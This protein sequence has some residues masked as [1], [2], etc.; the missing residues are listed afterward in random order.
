MGKKVASAS[1]DY[2]IRIMEFFMILVI[3]IDCNSIYRH[4]VDVT[5]DL[6]K[7]CMVAS[8]V[9]AF[10]LILL[11]I[12]KDKSNFQCILEYRAMFFLSA[13]FC[14]E[15]NAMNSLE[16]IR[17]DMNNLI[18]N[19]GEYF[20]GYFLFFM[21][22]MVILFRIYRK[23]QE[24]FRLLWLLE[25]VI[26]FLAI[27]SLILWVGTC[28]LELWGKGSDVY[29]FWGGN[30][31]YSNHLNLFVRRWWYEG[32]LKKNLGIFVEPPMYGLFLGFGLYTELFMK[33]KS[34]L[35]IVAIFVITLISCR[36]ILAL[37]ISL[38]GILFLFT[39]LFRKKKGA[40]VL[41]P[42]FWICA[43]LGAVALIIYKSKVGWGSFSVHVDDFVAC[44]KC[45]KEYPIFGCGYDYSYPIYNYVSSF[46]LDNLG[47][48][49]SAG[50]VLAEGGILLFLYYVIP[51]ALMMAAFFKGNRKLAYWAVGMFLFW[52][53]VIFHARA[54]VFF[55]MALGYSMIDVETHLFNKKDDQKRIKASLWIFKENQGDE[56][57][58]FQKKILNVPDGFLVMMGTILCL[59]VVYG[60][61]CGT[62]FAL[63]N[64]I[65]A[66]FVLI[67]EAVILF[68]NLKGKKFTKR[69]NTLF[70]MEF[71]MIYV[72]FGQAYQVL[73]DFLTRARLRTQD[74]WWSF[75]LLVLV[76]YG[77]G[78]IV[79]DVMKKRNKF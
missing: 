75:P 7:W 33:K 65:A 4:A 20:I 72:L 47:M 56:E 61:T 35:G 53:V 26:L 2:L 58:W 54:F 1:L 60:L 52:V 63:R 79:N 42:T 57:G 25:N 5:A 17:A 74:V 3:I 15:F 36:A 50:V 21:N 24:S 70:Q 19:Y 55:L 34:N 66:V 45:W 14:L 16:I 39:E 11:W 6:K 37:V 76:V 71:W 69:E 51:F 41:I 12:L 22:A 73:N 67:A 28:L 31:Y 44:F 32:D 8:N 13:V 78:L 18:S 46:R 27:V 40:K 68:L 10:T 29:V 48:S 43:F 62:K 49:N 23:N 64:T 30:H 59:T 9:A 38:G 77:I